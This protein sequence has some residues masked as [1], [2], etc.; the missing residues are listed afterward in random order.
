MHC[1]KVIVAQLQGYRPR[2]QVMLPR[3]RPTFTFYRIRRVATLCGCQILV[4]TFLLLSWCLESSL[5]QIEI[6]IKSDM[7]GFSCNILRLGFVN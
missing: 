7:F 4:T 5:K 2:E 3:L 6:C 1:R